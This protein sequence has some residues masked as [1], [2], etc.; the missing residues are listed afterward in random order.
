MTQ[1]I[2]Y[3]SDMT[4]QKLFALSDPDTHFHMLLHW[5]LIIYSIFFPN[6]QLSTLRVALDCETSYQHNN[7]LKLQASANK[8]VDSAQKSLSASN[9]ALD[10]RSEERLKILSVIM[11]H[12]CSGLQNTQSNM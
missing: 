6:S 9:V 2:C 7:K 8:D 3:T 11:L 1:K 4:E 12:L 5:K 10:D